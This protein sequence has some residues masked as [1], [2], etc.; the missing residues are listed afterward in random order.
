[1]KYSRQK[2]MIEQTVKD[3][4]VHLTAEEVY[5]LLKPEN[6]NLSLG[7]VYRNLNKLVENGTISKLTMSSGGD[8]FD[9]M[10]E[11]HSHVICNKCGKIFDIVG[12]DFSKLDEKVKYETGVTP[13]AHQLVIHGLCRDC[14]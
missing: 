12:G 1:M 13:L 5:G 2:Q 4:P 8:R 7:T 14:Q 9:G 3:N 10:V 6:P 11:E